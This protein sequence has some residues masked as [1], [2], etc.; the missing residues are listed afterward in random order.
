MASLNEAAEESCVLAAFVRFSVDGFCCF[1]WNTHMC[2]SE[3]QKKAE[4]TEE[5]GSGLGTQTPAQAHTH[6]RTT[7]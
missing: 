4:Q 5:K 3:R 2:A 6:T 1:L 7:Q